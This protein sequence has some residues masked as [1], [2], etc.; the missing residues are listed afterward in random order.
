MYKNKTLAMAVTAALSL[1]ISSAYAGFENDTSTLS[2]MSKA[3]GCYYATE[4]FGSTSASLKLPDQG[5]AK[6]IYTVDGTLD[7]V[8]N[9]VF[10]LD[11]G[12]KFEGTPKL[13][14]TE[15]STSAGTK[16]EAAN[17]A[18][19]EAN[20]AAYHYQLALNAFAIAA[21]TFVDAAANR[22]AVT[23]FA[24]DTAALEGSNNALLN[25][26]IDEKFVDLATTAGAVSEAKA[27]TGPATGG[28]LPNGDAYPTSF[29]VK[30][31]SVI[32]NMD[33]LATTGGGI[34]SSWWPN[35]KSLF[36]DW[37]NA[38]SQANGTAN[39]ILQVATNL[40]AFAKDVYD[41]K[42]S[43]T[44]GNL[45]YT[46]LQPALTVLQTETANIK[47]K[48]LIYLAA[49]DA[50]IA[51]KQGGLG[52]GTITPTRTMG[53]GDTS[54]T[55][56]IDASAK[57]E[58]ALSTGDKIV[59]EYQITNAQALK[60]EGQRINL[61]IEGVTTQSVTV[62]R[63]EKVSVA[64]SEQGTS[65]SLK[66]IQTDTGVAKISVAKGQ[67]E[68]SGSLENDGLY[69]N[70]LKAQLGKVRLTNNSKAVEM[71]CKTA[72]NVGSGT[73]K[74]ESSG[75]TTFSITNGQFAASAASPGSV[76]VDGMGSATVDNT[77]LTAV[78]ALTNEDLV[79]LTG[80]TVDSGII[81]NVDGKTAINTPEDAPMATLTIDYETAGYQTITYPSVTLPRIKLD[82]TVCS[83][84]NV[85]AP[86]AAD[87][88]SIRVTNNSNTDGNLFGAM[89]G[90]DGGELIAKGTN[91]LQNMT[92]NTIK[93]GETIR[94]SSEDLL[95]IAGG[96]PWDGRAIL[97]MT[98][99]L[100]N[101]EVMA[102]LRQNLAD[103]T[104]DPNAPLTNLSQDAF[105]STLKTKH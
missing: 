69:Q 66:S 73:A 33:T 78:W 92:S 72:W 64:T 9:V 24:N 101:I 89:Y 31:Q 98:S 91:L 25:M 14:F 27:G 105:G 75:K 52:G 40:V 83:V 39:N 62:F 48:G 30:A 90:K 68:F 5:T 76:Q 80:K 58:D 38:A 77:G 26:W 13:T 29:D 61:S 21:N 6:A 32:L 43:P 103:G 35:T 70:K 59:L 50:A 79:Q 49:N 3:D 82:G 12:A 17:T 53:N 23:T 22:G 19:N 56:Q 60:D 2:T 93:K 11:N 88:L 20:K 71:D 42:Q 55:F 44:A 67:T 47:S 65:L 15:D 99:N 1:G 86:G 63:T 4:I 95:A 45:A 97:R 10:T 16:L 41:K 37:A 18:A 96:T 102:L 54:V 28:K 74:I 46:A 57:P 84:Y 87:T 81:L 100:S 51:A 8:F 104:A 85:P 34:D 7:I 36:P 94:L